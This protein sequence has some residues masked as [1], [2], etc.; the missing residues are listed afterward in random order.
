MILLHSSIHS[1]HDKLYVFAS[2]L[3][4]IEYRKLMKYNIQ[5]IIIKKDHLFKIEN[6]YIFVVLFSF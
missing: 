4:R 5:V 1:M 3:Y 6:V 2:L